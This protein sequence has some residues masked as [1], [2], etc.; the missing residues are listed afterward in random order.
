MPYKVRLMDP[1]VDFLDEMPDK[2]RAKVLRSIG[3][4]KEFGPML[5]EPHA[6]R[7]PDWPGLFELRVD[8]GRLA[9]RMFY[10]W[11]RLSFY[12]MTSG[13]MKKSMKLDRRELN[14]AASLM[15]RFLDDEGMTHEDA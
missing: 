3:L 6:K 15:K 7:V 12:V 2:L 11:H 4:L 9:C 10:F 8:L 13:Y 5:R 1:A 14:R